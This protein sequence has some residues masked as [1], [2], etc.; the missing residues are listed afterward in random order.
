MNFWE[1]GKITNYASPPPLHPFRICF[2]LPFNNAHVSHLF[3][4]ISFHFIRSWSCCMLC[5][6][7]FFIYFQ[8]IA[9]FTWKMKLFCPQNSTATLF[10]KNRNKNKN[11]YSERE[12]E[13]QQQ[14]QNQKKKKIIKIIA[15]LS[16]VIE[17]FS[18]CVRYFHL[19]PKWIFFLLTLL[20][21]LFFWLF[22]PFVIQTIPSHF[23]F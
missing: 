22:V 14:Q 21:I 13:Q 9:V 2:T 11:K 6:C 1:N 15:N 23:Q 18:V 10:T 5:C 7:F 4:F 20:Q 16:I 12:K 8:S 19:I 3:Y 17:Y